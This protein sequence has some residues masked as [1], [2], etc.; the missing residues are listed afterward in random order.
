MKSPCQSP[1]WNRLSVITL[2]WTLAAL[3]AVNLHAAGP[4][5]N[6]THMLAA[7]ATDCGAGENCYRLAIRCTT[8]PNNTLFPLRFRPPASGR[9]EFPDVV[10]R[11]AGVSPAAQPAGGVV[12]FTGGT[13]LA[14]YGNGNAPDE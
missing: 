12:F 8:D 7:P 3:T 10:I 14:F 1:Y 2:A 9:T 5:A 11:E 13:G 4:T 6:G